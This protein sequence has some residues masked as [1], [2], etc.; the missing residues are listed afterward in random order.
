M[1]IAEY[2]QMIN[3]EG[4]LKDSAR[5]RLHIIRCG[6]YIHSD[7]YSLPVRPSPNLPDMESIYLYP[8]TCFFEGTKISPG[9][10]TATPFR[11]LGAP[12]L[13]GKYEF[14]F[15]PVSIPGMSKNPPY[16]NETCYGLDLRDT[17][18]PAFIREGKINLSWL[19]ELYKNYPDKNSF[20]VP[21]FE[22]LAGTDALRKQIIAG[23]SEK[24][25]RKTWK[26]ELDDFK[27]IRKKYLLY[28]D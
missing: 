13:K 26:K 5:C 12:A 23:R 7:L 10:G 24:Q 18:M 6:N 3:G 27:K 1:T 21:Y 28:E 9:R 19:I 22:K 11:I 14:S 17:G 16:I 20:F 8:S 25:I 2:A 15:V 4:W